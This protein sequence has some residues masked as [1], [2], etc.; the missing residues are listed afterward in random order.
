[1]TGAERLAGRTVVVTRA[2]DQAE[3]FVRLL[4]EAGATVL[5]APT[6]A[7]EPPRSWK[8]LD[9]AL[10]RLPTFT[11]IVFTSVNGVRMVD[12][13][14][15]ARGRAWRDV[16][17]PHV[18]AIGPATAAALEAHA[19]AVEVVPEEYR[20]EGLLERLRPR[21]GPGDRILLPRAER[22]REVLAA[23]LRT[24]G[25]EVTEVPAYTT[26]RVAAGAA[27]LREALAAGRV[28]AVTLTSSSTARGFAELFTPEERQAWLGRVTIASI[29]PVTA[30][31]AAAYGL[32]TRVM[33]REYTIP[34]LVRAI[35]EHF[36]GADEEHAGRRSE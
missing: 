1:M 14:L 4:R 22:A 16:T 17:G 6:I 26:R 29:G 24:L 21:I 13:R 9:E 31:S 11:W 20:A 5:E 25:A 27:A 33:P 2:A 34:A 15:E 7:I 10:E 23:G 30:A 28:D 35:E 36:G 3:G 18:A 32:T 12:R 19:V 8:P